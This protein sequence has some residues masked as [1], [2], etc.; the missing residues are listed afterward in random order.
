MK[1]IV[2]QHHVHVN[3]GMRN[4]E[5]VSNLITHGSKTYAQLERKTNVSETFH[6]MINPYE[7][8]WQS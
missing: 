3:E 1:T 4:Y 8:P 7:N 5:F 6:T 2:D